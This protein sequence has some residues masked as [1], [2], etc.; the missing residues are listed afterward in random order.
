MTSVFT[1]VFGAITETRTIWP[2]FWSHYFTS[3]SEAEEVGPCVSEKTDWTV[4]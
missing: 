4:I 1:T 3:L 2:I